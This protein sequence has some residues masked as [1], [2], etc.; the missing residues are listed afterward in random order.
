MLSILIYF[1]S[2]TILLLL[3]YIINKIILP[4]RYLIISLYQIRNKHSYM[5]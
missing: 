4:I 1:L 3:I 5:Y 2:N